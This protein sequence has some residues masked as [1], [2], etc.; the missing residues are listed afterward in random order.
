M[1]S[2]FGRLRSSEGAVEPPP[3]RPPARPPAPT[4]LPLG[5]ESARLGGSVQRIG[6]LGRLPV[7]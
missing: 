7:G 4:A 3:A 5:T 6:V 2:G 1:R